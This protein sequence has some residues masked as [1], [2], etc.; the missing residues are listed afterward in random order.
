MA[1][2]NIYDQGL[3]AGPANFEQLSP[4]RFIERTA[5]T[6]PDAPAVVHGDL[7]RNWGETYA[8]C[9]RLGSALT[10]RGIRRGDTV[11]VLAAIG[12]FDMQPGMVDQMHVIHPRGAGRHAA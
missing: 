8:R 12:L 10:R 6:F 1:H 9:R 4:L 3:E 7:R 11:A 2:P 5:V